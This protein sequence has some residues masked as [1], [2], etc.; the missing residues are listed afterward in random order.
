MEIVNSTANDIEEI[1]NLYKIATAFQK[2]KYIVQWPQFEQALIETEVAELR[3][4]KMLIDGQVAC[5]WATTFSDPQ[6]W[7]EKNADPAVYIHRIAT[8]PDFRGQNLVTAIVT[9]AKAY[10]RAHDKSFVR[11]DTVGEN[12]GLIHHYQKSGFNY[13]GLFNLKNTDQ[14]PA[15]YH[16]A[17]VSLFELVV[18]E[19]GASK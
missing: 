17:P 4:W 6:I 2:T 12:Q 7:E 9:W 1:F 16:N 14:L 19:S 15:H 10:A 13:L 8:H 11:L 18:N 3:Q 5:V